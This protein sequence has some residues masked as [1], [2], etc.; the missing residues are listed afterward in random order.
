MGKDG[1][2]ELSV[3]HVTRWFEDFTSLGG[4]TQGSKCFLFKINFFNIQYFSA[5]VVKVSCNEV[6]DESARENHFG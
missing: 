4:I 2:K 6:V 1:K 5:A 3:K